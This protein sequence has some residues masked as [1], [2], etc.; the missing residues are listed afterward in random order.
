MILTLFT[1]SDFNSP[2]LS[3]HLTDNYNVTR[4]PAINNGVF[5]LVDGVKVDLLAHKYPLIEDVETIDGIRIIS[6]M[7]IGAMKLN[8]IYNNGTRLKDFVDI[9]NLL[10]SFP[11]KD[12]LAAS[13]QKYPQNNIIMVKN[14]LLHHE[15]IDFD[16]LID[17]IGQY[18][19]WSLIADRLRESVNNTQKVF[20]KITPPHAEIT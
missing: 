7:D 2:E 5:C 14:A 4:I 19:K 17:F 6:L 10:E 1:T 8:A 18:I 9:Y 15:D 11:L 13:E 3:N 20:N 12:L 16:V